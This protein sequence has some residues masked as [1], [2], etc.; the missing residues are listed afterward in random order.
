MT[1]KNILIAFLL[2]LFFSVFELVGGF[3]TGSIAIVSDSVHDFSD[4]LTIGISYFLEKKSLK[5]A[6][7]N[8]TYGYNRYS[9]L[10]AFLTTSILI[11]GSFLVIF[12]S[13]SRIVNPVALNY[14]GMIFLAL[15]GIVING[16]ASFVTR[17]SH[18]LNQRSVNLHMLEDVLG[19]VVVFIGAIVI[20][21][22]DIVLI[23]S[24]MSIGVALFILI[25]A[26]KNMK[27]TLDLF[28]EKTPKD[29]D[30]D[31]IEK[32]L[33][34][35]DH[36]VSIHH[37]HFWSLDDNTNLATLHV[38]VDKNDCSIKNDIKNK[39]KDYG[40][41]HTTVEVESK[42]EKCMDLNCHIEKN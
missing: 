40:I 3:I 34:K 26:L 31:K 2:N 13:A 23:D 7:K 41:S 18:S 36:V 28:L 21:F 6:D 8:Y 4:A 25:E 29:I 30:V 16:I 37:L 38:V 19:W 15:I 1:K 17:D 11:I 33:L 32:D 27:D 35:I 9:I 39:L 12:N 10:G 22:T 20:K 14:D 24:I 42:D 5:K